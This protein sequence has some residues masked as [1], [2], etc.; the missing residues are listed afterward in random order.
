MKYLN[1]ILPPL[2]GLFVFMFI[3]WFF[4]ANWMVFISWFPALLVFVH[5][6]H[7][8]SMVDLKPKSTIVYLGIEGNPY[9]AFFKIGNQKFF[10]CSCE[11]EKEAEF[12]QDQLKKAFVKLGFEYKEDKKT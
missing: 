6:D 3:P 12:Y 4:D 1:V 9:R 7:E 2:V 11:T 10:V 8:I 5:L